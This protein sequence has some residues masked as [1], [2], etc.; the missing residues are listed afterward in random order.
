M[1]CKEDNIMTRP[2]RTLLVTALSLLATL[3]WASDR[4]T[5]MQYAASLKGLKKAELKTALYQLMKDKK[6][7]DYGNGTN[8]T[9]Y[10]FW[11][12]D[13]VAATNECFNRYSPKKFYFAAHNGQAI[14]GMNIEHSF[15]K[16]WWGGA[17]NDAYKDLYN[18][19]PSDSQANS[20]KS[21]FPMGVVTNVKETSG[22]GYD[23]VGTGDAGGQ[24]I[25]LWEPGDGFK[26]EFSRSYMY[27]ATTY[28]NF[29]WQGTQGLQQ[30][31][32]DLW[33]TLRSWA[34]TLYLA[35]SKSDPVDDVETARNDAVYSLQGN[36]NVFIDYPYLCEYVW[37]DS[38]DVAFDPT[39]SITTA[40]DDDRYLAQAQPAVA[41]PVIMPGSGAYM[42]PQ[43][44][45]LSCATEGATIYYTLDGTVPDEMSTPYT[46]AITIDTDVTLKAVAIKGD[47]KSDVAV[48]NYY[49]LGQGDNYNY[50]RVTSAPISGRHYLM[51]ADNS[52]KLIAARPVYVGTNTY[53]YLY[54]TS[55]TAVN[56]IVTLSTD[57]LAFTFEAAAGGYRIIDGKGRYY[58]QEGTYS[59]FTPTTDASKADIWTVTANSDGTFVI[60]ASDSGN[61]IQYSPRY[62]SYGNYTNPS[63]SNLYPML[64]EQVISTGISAP[65]TVVRR[66]D[67]IFY[68]LL[69]QPLGNGVPQQ[70]GIYIRDGK[71]VVVQ[72]P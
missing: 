9:W 40:Y 43:T 27:M 58:Y 31:Q 7:L 16:S 60:K 37:G 1:P 50:Q 38:V 46:G 64:F 8:N 71:K 10:G 66:P 18:L 45:T 3:T 44:V 49:F 14:S 51:V 69:G 62:S 67:G 33:P 21:N 41:K 11:Y 54:G 56:D 34:Y 68:N 70:P 39:T 72:H 53:G 2:F 28:Q 5:I 30:L 42:E 13:R 63:T 17:S 25:Q 48:A 47:D 24:T 57:T 22:E 32:N 35:W 20:S 19:Y 55:V 12:T 36:R 15:P 59:T 26:G 29:T 65:A 6:V 61:V 23:K 52:G 4:A